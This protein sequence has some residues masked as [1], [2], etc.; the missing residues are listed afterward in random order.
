MPM[1]K[2][3]YTLTDQEDSWVKSRVASGAYCNESAV[4]SQLIQEQQ[5]RE[6]ETPEEIA[7]IRAALIEGEE[8]IKQEGYCNQTVRE[9]W[10]EAKAIYQA[11]H[12]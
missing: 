2:K 11:K 10:E 5:V 3:N 8:S 6:H 1:V 12:G 9:I 4:I 7:A